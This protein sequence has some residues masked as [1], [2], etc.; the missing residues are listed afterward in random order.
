[1]SQVTKTQYTN[2]LGIPEPTTL[3]TQ[4][5]TE[6]AARLGKTEKIATVDNAAGLKTFVSR[7]IFFFRDCEG[8]GGGFRR[9]KNGSKQE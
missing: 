5:N 9:A 2:A 3:A 1:M 8:G 6:N 7:A 4:C